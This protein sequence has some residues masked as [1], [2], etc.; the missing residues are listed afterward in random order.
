MTPLELC[1]LIQTAV[2][3]AVSHRLS[4]MTDKLIAAKVRIAELTDMEREASLK[5]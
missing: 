2:L 4:K 1:V 3:I 5:L